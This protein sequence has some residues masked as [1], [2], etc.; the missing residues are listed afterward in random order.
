[1]TVA[2]LLRRHWR[3][4]LRTLTVTDRGDRDG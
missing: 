3:I 4:E 1:V 2:G